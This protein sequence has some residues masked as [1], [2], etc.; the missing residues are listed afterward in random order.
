VQAAPG[1]AQATLGVASHAGGRDAVPRGG[2][3][4]RLGRRATGGRGPRARGPRVAPRGWD[5]APPEAKGPGGRA[6]G[7]GRSRARDRDVV[8]PGARTAAREG[9][10]WPRRWGP[11]RP[12]ACVGKK[13]GHAGKEKG[14]GEGEREREIERG[15]ER[16]R[17]ERGA[18]LGI[19]KPAITVHRIT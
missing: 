10:G 4:P 5:A 16:E 15:R 13:Q 8:P 19:Q 1:A 14:E 3:A 7:L 18:H 2:R 11:G 12:R 6:P 17:E 9:L